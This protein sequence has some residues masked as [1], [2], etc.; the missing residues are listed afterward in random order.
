M[1]PNER[2]VDHRNKPVLFWLLCLLRQ[3]LHCLAFYF[4]PP[5][6]KWKAHIFILPRAPKTMYA[7]GSDTVTNI[8]PSTMAAAL[9]SSGYAPKISSTS[10]LSMGPFCVTQ[11]NP[12]DQ[13]TDPIQPSTIG[14]I[15]TQPNT[16][17][18]RAYSLVVTFLYT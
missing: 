12:T 17:N 16:T 15:W 10:E 8:R 13:L 6:P 4:L 9:D 18:N 1:M 2:E 7:T 5:L 14:K 3:L 11:S